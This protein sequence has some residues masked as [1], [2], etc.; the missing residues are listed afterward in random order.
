MVDDGTSNRQA[1]YAVVVTF[2]PDAGLP[3]RVARIAA[4]ADRVVVVDNASDVASLAALN[5]LTHLSNIEVIRNATNRGVATALN[6]GVALAT[7]GHCG[8]VWLFDQDSIPHDGMLAALRAVYANVPAPA[9]V[10]IVGTDVANQRA[11]S[12]TDSVWK[13]SPL[14]I[15][16]KSVITSGSLVPIAV[17]RRL[18]PFRDDFFI[19]HVDTEYCLR[20][21]AHGL[22]VLALR[23]TLMEHAIGAPS[24]HRI[25]TRGTSTSNHSASRRYYMTRNLSVVVRSYSGADPSWAVSAI[26]TWAKST[27]LMLAYER[28]RIAKLR[29]TLRGLVE[30][31]RMRPHSRRE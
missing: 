25:G 15:E 10:A 24:T 20:A 2:N 29:A 19:D 6:Q 18:G 23:Q 16:R 14:W 30:G 31:W 21:R 22:K 27:I 4:Q 26:A 13:G 3:A 9:S 12:G 7:A 17:L 5:A 11:W 28:D 1:V 8:W